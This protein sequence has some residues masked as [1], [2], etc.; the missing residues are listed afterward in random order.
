MAPAPSLRSTWTSFYPPKPNFTE[1][2]VSNLGGKV[3]L[4]TGSNTGVGKETARILYAKGAKVWVAAR[5]EEKANTAIEEIKKAEPRSTGQLHF[6]HFD[7]S[8][9][10][11]VKK[12]AENFLSQETKLHVLFNNAGVMVGTSE[13]TKTVQ[14]HE[15]ALGVNCIGTHLFTRLLTPLLIETAKAE[16]ANSV[17][18]VWLSS[19]GLELFG[20][21]DVGVALD[22]LDY[23]E[24]K[25]AAERYGIS[26]CGAWA[27]GVEYARRHK[28]DGIVSVPINP[29]NLTSEL[30]RD[31]PVALKMVVKVV[32]Y[33]PIMGA[34]TELFAGL[35]P[36]ITLEKS[37]DWGT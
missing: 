14:G 4:V 3:Y 33:P 6:L 11:E 30:A 15:L 20:A 10:R 24:P 8:D 35:S 25:A 36:E 32:G 16:P 18:V 26:K 34:Y 17:R 23:H 12:A 19:F 29:G 22:N 5:S 31:Q 13:A 7:L 1:K 37:G 9:L 21:Q 27:L 2:N 28:A